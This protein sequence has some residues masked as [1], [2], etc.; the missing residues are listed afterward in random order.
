MPTCLGAG[1]VPLRLQVFWFVP[2]GLDFF[3]SK[4]YSIYLF[5]VRIT[6]TFSLTVFIFNF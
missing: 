5:I 2:I 4:Q 3:P 6:V 1:R